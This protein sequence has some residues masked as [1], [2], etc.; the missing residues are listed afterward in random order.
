MMK[1]QKLLI[2]QIPAVVW[3]EPSDRVF[4]AVHGN[5][6]NKEDTVIRLLAEE[7]ALRGIQVISF[8]LPEHGERAGTQPPCKVQFCVRDLRKVMDYAKSRWQQISLFACS[9]GAYFSLLEYHA[10]PLHQALFLSPVVDMRRIIENM[11]TWFEVT[12][13]RLQKLGEIQTPI[14]QTLY[15][16]YYCYVRE[17]PIEH[18]NSETAILYGENDTLCERDTIDAFTRR[19]PC[20]LE[21]VNGGEHFFHTPEQLA[22]FSAWLRQNLH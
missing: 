3:G 4:L 9:M 5:L 15:W 16:D 22:A 18:W 2:D 21:V 6:S 10:E 19:F 8:D 20:K 17:R 11:M 12:E 14:G 1:T 7:A 13:E